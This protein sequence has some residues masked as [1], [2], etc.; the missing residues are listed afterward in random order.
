MKKIRMMKMYN[1]LFK[2]DLK[3]ILQLNSKND[4]TIYTIFYIF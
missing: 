4:F 1:F 2:F 3:I